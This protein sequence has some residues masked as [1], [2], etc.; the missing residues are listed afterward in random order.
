MVKPSVTKMPCQGK[1]CPLQHNNS[2]FCIPSIL[3]DDS[4][5]SIP[6]RLVELCNILWTDAVPLLLKDFPEMVLIL[7]FLEPSVYLLVQVVPYML[8]RVH[9]RA[10]GWPG[11]C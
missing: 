4:I 10:T 9:I 5:Q 1:N 8:N 2:I 11:K 6:H 7:G 3:T